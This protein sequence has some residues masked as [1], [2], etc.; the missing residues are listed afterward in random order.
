MTRLTAIERALLV[1]AL[2]CVGLLIFPPETRA[3]ST[4][5]S[6]WVPWPP[7]AGA[8][9][10]ALSGGLALLRAR[11]SQMIR[12]PASELSMGSTSADIV[13]STVLCEH[14]PLAPTCDERSFADELLQHRVRLSCG[15]GA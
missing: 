14:E 1:T 5:G 10:V 13:D 2:G 4:P 8:A 3:D 6:T 9:D 7:K 11:G 15:V 12:V